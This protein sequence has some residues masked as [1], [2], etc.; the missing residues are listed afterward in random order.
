MDKD[1]KII[2][3]EIFSLITWNHWVELQR[4]HS[5]SEA[6]FVLVY[7]FL[8][9]SVLFCLTGAPLRGPDIS[10]LCA[11]WPLWFLPTMLHS[12]LPMIPHWWIWCW[13]GPFYRDAVRLCHTVEPKPCFVCPY[14]TIQTREEFLSLCIKGKDGIIWQADMCKRGHGGA[15]TPALFP[16]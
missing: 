12:H 15:Q 9:L 1:T 8:L 2:I 16:N 13:E 4:E 7:I 11:F 10:A 14:Q 3:Y 6:G 5:V